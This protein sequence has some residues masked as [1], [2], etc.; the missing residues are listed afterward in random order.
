MIS[1]SLEER[2]S[3]AKLQP[4]SI[5]R[6]TL[7]HNYNIL[8]IPVTRSE[9][10]TRVFLH[11]FCRGL[12]VSFF[13]YPRPFRSMT[14]SFHRRVVRLFFSIES[15]RIA[16]RKTCLGEKGTTSLLRGLCRTATRSIQRFDA[17][18]VAELFRY[19]LISSGGIGR[20]IMQYLIFS[21]LK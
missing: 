17:S 9:R 16:T 13:L 14:F 15:M 11:E 12:V 19:P 3:R 5:L 21:D 4:V 1:R 18:L 2:W 10:C 7:R 6:G 20:Y 8:F